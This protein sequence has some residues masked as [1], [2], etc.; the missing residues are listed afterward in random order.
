MIDQ[1]VLFF[2]FLATV[3]VA[4][5]SFLVVRDAWAR[6][7]LLLLQ[8]SL[9]VNSGV[10]VAYYDVP[11][12][13]AIYHFGFLFVCLASFIFF[14]KFS[15]PF[16]VHVANR[17]E[18]ARD[19]CQQPRFVL[20]VLGLFYLA[21]LSSLVYPEFRLSLLFELRPPDLRAWFAERFESVERGGVE[22][23]VRYV[24]LLFF[25]FIFIVFYRFKDRPRIVFLLVFML[26]YIQYVDRQY[27][28]RGTVLLFVLCVGLFYFVEYPRTRK[29]LL[30]FG[31]SSVPVLA[32]LLE[33][34]M[35]VRLGGVYE[36]KGVWA[37][38]ERILVMQTSFTRDAG[39]ALI[40]SGLHVDLQKYFAWLLTLPIPKALIGQVDGARV[41]LEISEIVLGVQR[42]AP[43][44]YVILGGVVAES[45]YIFGGDLFW[46][47][48][49]ILGAIGAV[50]I[51][52]LSAVSYFGFLTA[53]T[54]VFFSYKLAG[55]GVGAVLPPLINEYLLLYIFM[56]YAVNRYSGRR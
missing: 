42:G 19:F 4:I 31:L 37:S 25:P 41:N 26:L 18:M 14:W 45:V 54:V 21:L 46:L 11:A 53:W 49:L 30:I 34:W 52:L 8:G 12:W 1:T 24:R 38:L 33:Y 35:V 50:L 28:A 44:F 40:E 51:R 36:F 47:H 23:V 29:W 17:V 16:A 5:F 9:F 22:A 10:A 55:A 15:G 48:G 3:V 20:V 32:V 2:S 27:I 56:A 7:A 39:L 6:A 43:G 13:F